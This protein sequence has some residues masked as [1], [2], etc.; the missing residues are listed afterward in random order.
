M[1]RCSPRAQDAFPRFILLADDFGC[2]EAAP[3][4]LLGKGWP[5]R[6]DVT[7]RD[8]AAWLEE[9]VAAGMACLWTVNERRYCYLT[10][11][12][13]EHGQKHRS[14]YVPKND[15]QGRRPNEKGSKR[16]TPAPPAELVEAVKAGVRRTVD[17]KPP[18]TDREATPENPKDSVP[19]RE[20]AGKL[21]FPGEFPGSAVPDADADAGT[22]SGPPAAVADP[23]TGVLR[24]E[25]EAAF[26]ADRREPYRWQGAK[27]AVALKRIA[28][29]SP[30]EFRARAEKGL[31]ATGYAR[32]SSVAQLVSKWN[33]LAGAGPAPPAGKPRVIAPISDFTDEAKAR[34]WDPTKARA[35]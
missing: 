15:P 32:C 9:Y 12:H 22:S 19:E 7:E 5:L 29:V 18:G 1:A 14:E 26:V 35:Q 3:R 2:L 16:K 17:G 27:D 25:W 24:R 8:V 33:D 6:D 21:D 30:A 13:G 20:T 11:W 34:A 28:A 23:R 10:G 31:R 4:V